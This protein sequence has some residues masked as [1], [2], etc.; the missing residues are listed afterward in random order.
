MSARPAQPG[1]GPRLT[2]VVAAAENGVIGREGTLPWHLPEDLKRFKALTL[3]KP[4][5][6]GRRTFDS[7]G[8]VLPGRQTIVLTRST[9]WSHP[10][11]LVAHSLQEAIQLA[12]T[13][14]ELCVIG[15]ADIF[16]LS[17]PRAERIH[18]TRIHAQVQGE[19]RLPELGAEWR[20]VARE[21][22]PADERN[23]FAM[24]FCRLERLT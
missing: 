6:M 16:A 23:A 3:G 8:R 22:Y 20:E 14:P 24:T 10:Q 13:A 2:L 1:T 4:M 12:G 19:T 7:I 5:L 17:L 11:V 9:Q 21:F 15:G 18:L